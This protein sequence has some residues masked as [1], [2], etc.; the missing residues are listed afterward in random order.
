MTTLVVSMGWI[1][2]DATLPDN[3]PIMKGFPY[4][5]KNE[6]EDMLVFLFVERRRS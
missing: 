1:T 2:A 4:F 5:S 6:S 3:E